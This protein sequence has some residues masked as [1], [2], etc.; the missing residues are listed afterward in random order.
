MNSILIKVLISVLIITINLFPQE[1]STV[2]FETG[3]IGIKLDKFGSVKVTGNSLSYDHIQRTS[4]LVSKDSTHVFD[5]FEDA[6]NVVQPFVVASPQYGDHE[7]STTINNSYSSKQPDV[8]IK[9]NAYGWN[10]SAFA[11]L[12]FEIKNNETDTLNSL[13]GLEILPSVENAFGKEVVK[14][15]PSKS[16]I[17]ISKNKFV[18]F[19]YLSQRL[20]SNKMFEWKAGYGKDT[21]Y[22]KW[23]NVGEIDT[24]YNAGNDGSVI[25]S[26]H[27]FRTI[28]PGGVDSLWIA[29]AV[30]DSIE[31]FNSNID[32]AALRIPGILNNIKET[33]LLSNDYQLFQNYPNPFNPVTTI[34]YSIPT[35][36]KGEMSNHQPSAGAGIK[37]VVYDMLGREVAVLINE[38]K[39]PGNYEVQWNASG[40]SSGIYFYRLKTGGYTEIRKMLLLK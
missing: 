21:S 14:V 8:S 18:G 34:K 31:D 29:V 25:I 30:G 13:L 27:Y 35:N 12:R 6:G 20:F 26:S 19:R 24:S 40:F 4:I 39:P 7:L 33:N 28:A 11:L 2:Y 10:G 37:L 15:N 23:M 17:R 3:G 5:Y 36:A 32:S 22:F 1:E 9:I 16:V 38:E